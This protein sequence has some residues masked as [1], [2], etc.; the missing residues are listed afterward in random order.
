MVAARLAGIPR[1]TFINLW[2]HSTLWLF[3]YLTFEKL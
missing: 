2:H 1:S 3:K